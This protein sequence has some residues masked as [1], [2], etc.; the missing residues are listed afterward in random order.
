MNNSMHE[1]AEKPSQIH[2][3]GLMDSETKDEIFTLAKRMVLVK[4]IKFLLTSSKI[5]E[6]NSLSERILLI[7]GKPGYL[8]GEIIMDK[9]KQKLEQQKNEIQEIL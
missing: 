2:I 9:Y 6:T 1:K 5:T 4:K 3:K 7:N 8:P